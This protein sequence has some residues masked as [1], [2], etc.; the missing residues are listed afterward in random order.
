L[1]VNESGRGLA[2]RLTK[3]VDSAQAQLA[4]IRKDMD[5]PGVSLSALRKVHK[6]PDWAA[7]AD[8]LTAY[9]GQDTSLKSQIRT[10]LFDA[11]VP[12]P[13][14]WWTTLMK[15]GSR[16]LALA[17]LQYQSLKLNM[18]LHSALHYIAV[19]RMGQDDYLR[20]P[21]QILVLAPVPG[22][23]PVL[24]RPFQAEIL[25]KGYS[26]IANNLKAFINCKQVPL[27]EGKAH[28][29]TVF[30]K[31]GEQVI[32]TKFEVKNPL[33]GELRNY[34]RDFTLNVLPECTPS[35]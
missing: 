31:P 19:A 20:F 29:K 11:D 15:N 24:N 2:V 25:L 16:E 8:S 1:P 10:C 32:T 6:M 22:K 26:R 34:T 3:L 35:N 12:N 18:A 7:I 23:I 9:A 30:T 21:D 13:P 33:T 28:Y 14:L 17:F 5:I 27:I 4:A